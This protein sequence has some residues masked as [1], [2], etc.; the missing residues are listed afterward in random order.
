M[1]YKYKFV[2]KDEVLS[3]AEHALVL[4]TIKRGQN[5]IVL[6]GGE[7]IIN[8]NMVGVVSPTN[9]L[10]REQEKTALTAGPETMREMDLRVRRLVQ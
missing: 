5:I 10:T 1:N 3:E 6:R 7:L 9:T 4:N 2:E 8:M